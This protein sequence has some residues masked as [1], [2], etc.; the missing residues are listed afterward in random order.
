MPEDDNYLPFLNSPNLRQLASSSTEKTSSIR[1]YLRSQ[2]AHLA[3][4]AVE[5]KSVAA[6]W[7][8]EPNAVEALASK[9]TAVERD[10]EMESGFGTPILKHRVRTAPLEPA[11]S[12]SQGASPEAVLKRNP[13]TRLKEKD[14]G[15]VQA[16]A[17]S[18][19]KHNKPRER[20]VD[21]NVAKDT[22]M[23]V[24]TTPMK[25]RHIR[26]HEDGPAKGRSNHN[27][28]VKDK[29]GVAKVARK[30]DGDWKNAGTVYT[31]KE[32]AKTRAQ[33][34]DDDE[35]YRGRL[36]ERRE[37]RRAKKAI[38]DPKP[39]PPESGS[40][41]DVDDGHR[42]RSTK[43]TS[44]K[45][46]KGKGLNMPAGLALMHGF[47]ATNIGKN[48][49]TLNPVVGVFN[50]GKASAKTVVKIKPAKAYLKLF[51]EQQ[52][53]DRSQ[54]SPTDA[55]ADSDE[56][57]STPRSQG[58]TAPKG[59]LIFAEKGTK[60]ARSPSESAKSS[61]S[62]KAS[63][64][65]C[66]SPVKKQA[67]YVRKESPT[68]DIEREDGQLPAG[69]ASDT[70]IPSGKE[71]KVDGTIVLDPRTVNTRWAATLQDRLANA[72]CTPSKDIEEHS[73]AGASVVSSIA[74]SNSASQA[75]LR[76][77]FSSHHQSAPT[78]T[79]SK[80][81]PA[82]EA[83]PGPATSRLALN[84]SPP[85]SSPTARYM[86]VRREMSPARDGDG[87]MDVY[88][89][90]MHKEPVIDTTKA[91][92]VLSAISKGQALGHPRFAS[93]A[94]AAL[95]GSLSPVLSG[96]PLGMLSGP[97]SPALS[98]FL[99]LLDIAPVRRC[100]SKAGS[101]RRRNQRDIGVQDLRV[102]CHALDLGA[103]TDAVMNVD[104]RGPNTE[105]FDVALPGSGPG[106]PSDTLGPEYVADGPLS[107]AQG[108]LWGTDDVPECFV[109]ARLTR[110]DLAYT[111]D[112]YGLVPAR[113]GQEDV[114]HDE[115]WYKE[116]P[117]GYSHPAEGAF[118]EFHGNCPSSGLEEAV[119][120]DSEGYFQGPDNGANASGNIAD[121]RDCFAGG[122]DHLNFGYDPELVPL[123]ESFDDVAMAM[124]LDL[125]ED[126]DL[127]GYDNE[128]DHDRSVLGSLQ[129]FSQG[130]ALLMG[131]SELEAKGGDSS[132]AGASRVEE[133]VAK[134]L[135][136]H[137]QRQR[138]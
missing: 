108:H 62:S 40:E 119:A 9:A 71:S 72:T 116:E 135:K 124:D 110:S 123:V 28:V 122:A 76:R 69:S 21:P 107:S 25:G 133:D 117:Y 87:F 42:A 54:E 49:L 91:G 98:G 90:P 81:F 86:S 118:D 32:T 129:R 61:S 13:G 85:S 31:K 79:F 43:K 12:S 77:H 33:E 17:A 34:T 102:S 8:E 73:A 96:S 46:K 99:G 14:S 51:S 29:H 89:A 115:A 24:G 94:A 93:T 55:K 100:D 137:W 23:Q 92:T 4:Y 101:K 104:R 50:K 19:K 2:E 15:R 68:W 111:A 70:S 59:A 16:D 120:G 48:R 53:L 35:E 131:V 39:N 103:G 47:S 84:T 30:Q 7:R 60:R 80:F 138:F 18:T 97:P 5:G 78:K 38:V 134:T 63:P 132:R 44:K 22:V 105:M 121:E 136:G 66:R 41:E 58:E 125:E 52:F 127:V 57:E 126:D 95:E 1:S 88:L 20:R 130:R 74:P 56:Q 11:E 26:G 106:F 36:A 65:N 37:R 6:S 83:A 109:E 27:G 10:M 113:L 114:S 64:I 128:S 3:S 67:R 45:G 112:Q 75:A 82:P